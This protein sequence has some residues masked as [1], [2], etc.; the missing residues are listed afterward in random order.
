MTGWHSA[1]TDTGGGVAPEDEGARL[2]HRSGR[3]AGAAIARAAVAIASLQSAWAAG[4]G[5]TEIPRQEPTP[6]PGPVSRPS[7]AVIL[8]DRMVRRDSGQLLIDLSTRDEMQREIADALRLVRAAYPEVAGVHA[9]EQYRASMLILGLEPPLLRR[10]QGMFDAAGGVVTLRTGVRELDALNARLGL[11]GARL[12]EP[13][14]VIF[15]FGP[16]LNVMAAAAAYARLDEV[17]YAEPDTYLGDGPDIAAARAH[18]EW[19]LVFRHAW[20]DCPSGCINEQFFVFVI[21]GGSVAQADSEA[22]PIRRLM[23]DRGWGY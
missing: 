9:R 13:L 17:S 12:L 3:R 23:R 22:P 16:E 15:C 8:A 10:A 19:Y 14:G 2:R 4:L 20:G 5:E 11:R 7:D 1:G 18:G 21:T 6:C